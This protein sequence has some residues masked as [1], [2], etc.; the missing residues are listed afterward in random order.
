MAR[1]QSRINGHIAEYGVVARFGSVFVG[2]FLPRGIAPT[3]GDGG[4][5]FGRGIGAAHVVELAGHRPE[6]L[7]FNRFTAATTPTAVAEIGVYR[8]REAVSDG[9][10]GVFVE[11]HGGVCQ[12]NGGKNHSFS[13]NPQCPQSAQTAA[14]WFD[15]ISGTHSGALPRLVYAGWGDDAVG[16]VVQNRDLRPTRHNLRW[17]Q[18]N[19]LTIRGLSWH[20]IHPNVAKTRAQQAIDHGDWGRWRE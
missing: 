17:I 5:A 4:E 12:T 15:A 8:V 13:P 19:S 18:N 11:F 1:A 16:G 2:L 9:I 10:A 6:Q 20:K 14:A 3:V 7:G